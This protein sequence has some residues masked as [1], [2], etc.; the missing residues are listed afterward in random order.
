MNTN[1]VNKLFMVT[2]ILVLSIFYTICHFSIETHAATF[3][4]P[5]KCTKIEK[6]NDDIY[7]KTTIEINNDNFT[8]NL[9]ITSNSTKTKTAS[10]T[11]EYQ[12][13]EGT[14][15]WYVKVTGTFTYNGITSSC[16]TSS[17]SAA[18]YN[19]SWTISNKT[20]Y[21]SG[22]T[23]YASATGIKKFMSVTVQTITRNVSLSCSKNGTLS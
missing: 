1:K 11:V 12:N 19:S 3:N 14:T 21:K 15:L 6:I 9:F 18:S 2:I 20:S 4:T 8:Q 13:S 17:V 10:K 22:N 7:C 5:V 23:A 16:S